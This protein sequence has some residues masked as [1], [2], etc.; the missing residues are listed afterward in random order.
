MKSKHVLAVFLILP[1][2]LLSA[3]IMK[4]EID[5]KSDKTVLIRMNGFDPVDLLSGHYLLLR[6]DWKGTNC[7]QFPESICPTELFSYSY[8]YYLPEFDARTVD[9]RLLQ[10]AP[11]VEMEFAIR[12]KSKPLVKGLLI[13]GTDW[14]QWLN[15]LPEETTTAA[16]N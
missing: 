15:S 3:W 2:L 14:K 5:L 11:K 1:V 10:D 6:P 7:A 8:R 16:P 12:G 4:I 13:N 9:R